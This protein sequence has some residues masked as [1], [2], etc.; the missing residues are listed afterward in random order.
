IPFNK[1]RAKCQDRSIA[2]IFIVGDRDRAST[3]TEC[4]AS[5]VF[6]LG[7]QVHLAFDFSKVLVEHFG[8]CGSAA[9]S[10]RAA[11]KFVAQIVSSCVRSRREQLTRL[12]DQA[13]SLLACIAKRLFYSRA[14]WTG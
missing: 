13:L 5:M 2:D 6:R 1:P 10:A 14:A 4:A 3:V 9:F 8:R 7:V 11:E 12:I